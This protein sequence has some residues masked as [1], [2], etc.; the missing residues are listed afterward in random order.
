[1]QTLYDTI[2]ARYSNYRRPDPRIV[3]ALN[4]ELG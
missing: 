4:A 1:M 2:G 3:A